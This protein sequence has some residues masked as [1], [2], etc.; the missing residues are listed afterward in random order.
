MH[1]S[2]RRFSVRP[3]SKEVIQEN[4]A[5]VTLADQKGDD[6]HMLQPLSDDFQED[7]PFVLRKKNK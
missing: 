1:Y 4:Q 6:I 3:D 7:G 2:T 5:F